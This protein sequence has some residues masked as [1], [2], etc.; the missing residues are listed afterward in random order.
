VVTEDLKAPTGSASATHTALLTRSLQS[1]V[2]APEPEAQ[3]SEIVGLASLT[4][5]EAAGERSDP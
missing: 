4:G 2:A 1:L 3:T 5:G